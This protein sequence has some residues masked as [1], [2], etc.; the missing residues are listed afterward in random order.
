L[1]KVEEVAEFVE[2]QS[3]LLSLLLSSGTFTSVGMSSLSSGTFTSVDV[4]SFTVSN[5]LGKSES[6]LYAS[7]GT[8]TSVV[9]A[10]FSVM[11]NL[12]PEVLGTVL[13]GTSESGDSSS[14]TR[15]S[16]SSEELQK[17]EVL[18]RA[19][20]GSV[21]LGTVLGGISE[22]LASNE[23]R[24]TLEGSGFSESDLS[25]GNLLGRASD[26]TSSAGRFTLIDSGRFTEVGSLGKSEGSDGTF[27]MV[28]MM[29]VAVSSFTVSMTMM[30]VSSFTVSMVMV[31]MGNST[32]SSVGVLSSKGHSSE[33]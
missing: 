25:G 20:G 16:M 10:T 22:A 13:D 5:S 2:S 21:V 11:S 30:V 28:M 8:F 12:V 19:L 26:D 31:M 17:S 15:V 9:V 3:S 27:T 32:F 1:V 33:S 7:S 18:G 4:S 29:V 14:F 6:L 23:M 24:F